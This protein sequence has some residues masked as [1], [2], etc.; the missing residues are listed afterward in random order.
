[1]NFLLMFSW[2]IQERE[3][4]EEGK[5]RQ[6]WNSGH[7]LGECHPHHLIEITPSPALPGSNYLAFL[8]GAEDDFQRVGRA[9]A[10]TVIASSLTDGTKTQVPA[11]PLRMRFIFPQLLNAFEHIA[12]NRSFK[13]LHGVEYV[14]FQTLEVYVGFASSCFWSWHDDLSRVKLEMDQNLNS[15]LASL[16]YCLSNRI[17]DFWAISDP[18]AGKSWITTDCL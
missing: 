3:G 12:R 1:M 6:W 14:C 18:H 17:S 4:G 10:L 13:P 16:L 7:L 9:S 5:G 11:S 2:K 8:P 15:C